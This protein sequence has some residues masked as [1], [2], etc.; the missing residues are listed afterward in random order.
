[1]FNRKASGPG[2]F[3]SEIMERISPSE[4]QRIADIGAGGGFFSLLFSEKV[5]PKGVVYAVDIEPVFLE[6]I[7]ERA[8]ERGLRNIRVVRG[9]EIFD[10]IPGNELDIVFVRNT[11]HHLPD[12]TSYFGE[13]GKL[14]RPGGKVI[15]IDYRDT[16]GL[17]FHSLFGHHVTME[18][19]EK[20]MN[21]AGFLL[22]RSYGF[23]PRQWFLVFGKDLDGRSPGTA[24]GG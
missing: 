5:G 19:V 15:I 14:L 10:S 8:G 11:Y 12:R 24:P 18:T 1:M 22:E 20:E 21:G 17:S 2:S 16:G 6:Y 23:L 13:V 7:L 3:P 4:G 9:G